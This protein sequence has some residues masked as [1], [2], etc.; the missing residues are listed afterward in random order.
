MEMKVEVIRRKNSS[1]KSIV[2]FR[3]LSLMRHNCDEYQTCDE[4][5][6]IYF[7]P[8]NVEFYVACSFTINL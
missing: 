6:C 8:V 2:T 5:P 4:I 1:S 3:L 7:V